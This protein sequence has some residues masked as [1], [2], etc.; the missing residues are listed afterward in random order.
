MP[1]TRVPTGEHAVLFY[2]KDKELVE[3]VSNYLAQAIWEEETALVIATPAH[4]A[5]FVEALKARHIDVEGAISS[6]SLVLL[7]AASALS[8]FTEE[9]GSNEEQFRTVIGG[10]IREVL[11]SGRAVRAFGE[12][13]ALLWDQ[14]DVLAAI[15]L[16]ALW[17]NLGH[18]LP[19]ALFC[20]YPAG[21]VADPD[22]AEALQR[23]CHLH[24]SVLEL[25]DSGTPIID[26]DFP[27]T[28]AAPRT[29]RHLVVGKLRE[30]GYE[31]E[32]I[33]KIALAVTELATN[34]LRHARSPFSILVEEG[35]TLR[36]AVRDNLT[37]GPN[38]ALV[39]AGHGLG[40]I[41]ALASR[42][43][44]DVAADG[45]AVW[46]EFAPNQDVPKSRPITKAENATF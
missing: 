25:K 35:I 5:A 27:V 40:L 22:Q 1:A 33:G 43:G 46:A 32:L 41:A 36:V 20:A 21:L 24:S 37:Q 30:Q 18:E 19:F 23:V 38:P 16:E 42:W 6:E 26:A 13:V 3:A 39:A 29:A 4:C 9:G 44:I 31:E 8:Q 7:D 14:G 12:M 45:K 10:A 11:T 15:E 2:E 17:N 34:A 28:F